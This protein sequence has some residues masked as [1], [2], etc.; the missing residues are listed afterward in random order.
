MTAD[1]IIAH[2]GLKQHPEGGHYRETWIAAAEGDARPAGTA[3]YF[4]LRKGERSHWHRVDTTEI[5]HYYAGA[6]ITLRIAETEAGPAR[7][8]PLGPALAAGEMPQVIVSEGHWQSAE[9]TG[10]WTLVG[11]T[12][13]PAFRFEGFELAEPGFVIP[14]AP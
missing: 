3:I 6:P 10:D 7:I 4:L 12:V 11:C 5:W 2:L 1:Q 13:S 8:H 14:D 9:S